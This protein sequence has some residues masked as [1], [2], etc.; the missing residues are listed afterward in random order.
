MHL[1]ANLDLK[2]PF[3]I[4]HHLDTSERLSM[5]I[6]SGDTVDARY[7]RKFELEACSLYISSPGFKGD[8]AQAIGRKCRFVPT[9]S[10][11]RRRCPVVCRCPCW[12]QA[13]GGSSLDLLGNAGDQVTMICRTLP[14]LGREAVY[15]RK[16]P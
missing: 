2:T 6:I 7:L 14:D 10:K 16:K 8:F 15:I 3:Y 4:R 12:L 13:G 11:R 1:S 9:G 5:F